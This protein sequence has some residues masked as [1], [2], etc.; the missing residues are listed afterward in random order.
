MFNTL[1][2][3]LFVCQSLLKERRRPPTSGLRD[4]FQESLGG[5]VVGSK[6]TAGASEV[7]FP[8]PEENDWLLL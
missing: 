2:E 6:T 1:D 4:A 7:R 3:H 5:G 8:L